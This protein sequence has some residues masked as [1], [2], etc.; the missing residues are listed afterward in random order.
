M[1]GSEEFF[2]IPNLNMRMPKGSNGINIVITSGMEREPNIE[3]RTSGN[4]KNLE[5]EIK[6]NLGIKPAIKEE[7]PVRKIT[8]VTEEPETQLKTA[9]NRQ[10]IQL[11]LPEIKNLSD[12]EVKKLEQSM[13]IKA[14]AKDK[15]YFKLI[16][17]SSN[18]EIVNKEFKN[19]VLKI[20]LEK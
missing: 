17:I 10:T 19:N 4:F 6:R 2:K 3:V 1:F 16:P 13:E 7:E 11:K 12:I 9:G 15:T 20:E 14:F 18:F 8:K 5:P